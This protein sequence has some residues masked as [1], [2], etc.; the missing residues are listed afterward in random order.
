MCHFYLRTGPLCLR[1]LYKQVEITVCP[2]K[3]ER[4]NSYLL[5]RPEFLVLGSLSSL[6]FLQEGRFFQEACFLSEDGG[7]RSLASFP[8]PHHKLGA[9][10]S[11]EFS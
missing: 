5:S 10:Q 9:S 7:S 6:T 11:V 8:R 3:T 2:F 1:K 4:E